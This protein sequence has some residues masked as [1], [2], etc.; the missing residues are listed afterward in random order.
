MDWDLRRGAEGRSHHALC[1]ALENKQQ[2]VSWESLFFD[3]YRD[4]LTAEEAF[5]PLLELIGKRY[6]LIAYLCYLKDCSRFVPIATKSFDKA[7]TLLGVDLKTS[8]Q[9]SWENYQAYLGVLCEVRDAL[10]NECYDDVRLIDAHSFCWMIAV[11]EMPPFQTGS[12]ISAPATFAGTLRPAAILPPSQPKEHA[13]GKPI[14]W[15]SL[16]RRQA[17]VGRIA[18][19]IALE[20]EKMRLEE[21]G[22]ADLAAQVSLVADEHT[23]GYDIKSFNTDGTD[24]H[25]EVKAARL[26]S[27]TVSFFRDFRF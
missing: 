17:E 25:I 6:D 22:R 9:C 10:R 19:A 4:E 24:R 21:E 1:T 8:W 16:R 27:G 14:D 2:L 12:G 7:F 11:K 13:P 23:L 26:E 18:E 5:P 15:D 20:S 3:F